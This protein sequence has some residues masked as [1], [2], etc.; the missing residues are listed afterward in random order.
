MT[1]DVGLSVDSPPSEAEELMADVDDGIASVDSSECRADTGTDSTILYTASRSREAS[2]GGQRVTQESSDE[3]DL[4]I[5]IY[6]SDEPAESIIVDDNGGQPIF[7][8]SSD[9]EMG[10][11]NDNPGQSP[12]RRAQRKQSTL[13]S[14]EMVNW[15]SREY[16][17]K[18]AASLAAAWENMW[19]QWERVRAKPNRR[20]A[21]TLYPLHKKMF[22][23]WSYE[24]WNK[25]YHKHGGRNLYHFWEKRGVKRKAVRQLTGKRDGTLV[26]KLGSAL[27]RLQEAEEKHLRILVTIDDG[28]SA[29]C[30]Y[31]PSQACRCR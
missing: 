14:P 30:D 13:R 2:R 3:P 12:R 5:S 19:E 27:K 6:E 10:L 4:P 25:K 20:L 9:D 1:L 17:A 22:S 26:R 31:V 29:D 21:Q 24:L 15:A 8:D 18:S 7:I 16:K 11:D 28:E 23:A